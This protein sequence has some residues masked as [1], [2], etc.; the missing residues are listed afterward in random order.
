MR[1]DQLYVWQV[2]ED[3][4]W[5]TI[6]GLPLERPGV[7]VAL[8]T[9]SREIAERPMRAYAH[10]HARQTGKEIRLSLFKLSVILEHHR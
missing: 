4:G 7:S 10:E 1:G 8:V 5:A 2:R 6:A 9:R 3:D